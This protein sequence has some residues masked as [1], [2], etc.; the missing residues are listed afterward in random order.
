MKDVEISDDALEDLNWDTC[1]M[2]RKRLDSVSILQL[3][4]GRILRVS[5]F[6]PVFIAWST[7]TITVCLARCFRMGS[8]TP[9]SRSVRLFGPL[10]T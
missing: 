4:S 10:S 3:A 6:L 8:F 7:V 5:E 1:F 9:P 2:K